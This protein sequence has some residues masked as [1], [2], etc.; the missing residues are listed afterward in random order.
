MPKYYGSI[1]YAIMEK[2]APGRVS[3][4]IVERQYYGDVTR[5]RKQNENGE[6]LNDNINISN[7][8]SIVADAF[9]YDNFH[10]IQYITYMG[11]K[12]KVKSVEVQRPRLLLSI[13]GVYNEQST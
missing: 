9:A 6:W 5:N 1:G 13:G 3:P 2:T 10:R 4:I 8:I 12:W 7:E 11:A